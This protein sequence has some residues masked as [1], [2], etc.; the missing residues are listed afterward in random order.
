MIKVTNNQYLRSYLHV[1]G[2]LIM[3]SY[4]LRAVAIAFRAES[5]LS[6]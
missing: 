6:K 5:R 2:A 4:F 3:S 1:K